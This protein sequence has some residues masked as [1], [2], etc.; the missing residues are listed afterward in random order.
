MYIISPI[1]GFSLG[2]L[3]VPQ[4]VALM[5]T[6]ESVLSEDP[7]TISPLQCERALQAAQVL[8]GYGNLKILGS[9]STLDLDGDG[10]YDCIVG[11]GGFSS[12][13]QVYLYLN[14]EQQSKYV[15]RVDSNLLVGPVSCLSSSHNGLCD[16]QAGVLMIHGEA[17]M[18]SYHFNGTE[19]LP[20]GSSQLSIPHPK[21]GP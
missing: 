13:S 21:F 20:V 5:S 14:R 8:I 16:I 15:G 18:Q 4:S 17:K 6:H 12:N 19:Y 2:C 9:H 3:K 1:L 10:Q 7:K 11:L